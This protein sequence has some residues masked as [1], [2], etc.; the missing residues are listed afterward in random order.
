MVTITAND[1]KRKGISIISNADEAIITV[2]GKPTYVILN[3]DY[4]EKLRE[5]E[6]LAALAETREDIKKGNFAI[7]TIEEHMKRITE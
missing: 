1:I 2:H 7:G 4:Y 5:A 3:I 6:L